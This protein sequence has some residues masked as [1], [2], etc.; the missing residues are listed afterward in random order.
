MKNLADLR[1]EIEGW[2]KLKKRIDD[3]HEPGGIAG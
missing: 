2:Q 1:D 3:V